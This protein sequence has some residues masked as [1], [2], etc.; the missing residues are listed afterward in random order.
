MSEKR[1][2]FAKGEAEALRGQDV[3]GDHGKGGARNLADGNRPVAA[4]GDGQDGCDQKR[5]DLGNNVQRHIAPEIHDPCIFRQLL[6]EQATHGGCQGQCT[7]QRD[8]AWL[9]VEHG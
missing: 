5:A 7:L 2:P 6:A 3:G 9:L 1:C 4:G 8:Q